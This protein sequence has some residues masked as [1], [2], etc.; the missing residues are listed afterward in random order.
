MPD[1]NKLDQFDK[2]WEK[3]M[4]YREKNATL[5]SEFKKLIIR[6]ELMDT[7]EEIDKMAQGMLSSY[8]EHIK[9][10]ESS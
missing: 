8:I 2:D 10:K 6:L 9:E 3:V 7:F 5:L 1:Q 4:K